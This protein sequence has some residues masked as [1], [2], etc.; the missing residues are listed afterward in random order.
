MLR[1]SLWLLVL[2][3][4]GQTLVHFFRGDIENGIANIFITPFLAWGAWVLTKRHK[5]KK[6]R[7]QNPDIQHPKVTIRAELRDAKS[8]LIGIFHQ[9]QSDL[10]G[11]WADIKKVLIVDYSNR[12]KYPKGAVQSSVRADKK[13][14]PVS[15]AAR[16]IR[17]IATDFEDPKKLVVSRFEPLVVNR[18]TKSQSYSGGGVLIVK[19]DGVLIGYS[20]ARSRDPKLKQ[21]DKKWSQILTIRPNQFEIYLEDHSY[22]EFEPTNL[23]DFLVLTVF[24]QVFQTAPKGF[25]H[26]VGN[27]IG[28]ALGDK[29]RLVADYLDENRES[30]LASKGAIDI[31][32]FDFSSIK[33]KTEAAA[34]FKKPGIGSIL[35]GYR[36]EAQ[37]GRGGFGTV[38][39]GRDTKN[40]ENAVAFKLMNLPEGR[41]IKVGSP[42]FFYYSDRFMDEAKKSLNFTSSAYVLNA[43]EM[44]L[45]PW[46]WIAYPLVKGKSVATLLD[47][48]AVS[49]AGW[50]NLAH[51]LLSG[52]RS[53]DIE[54]LVHLDIKPDNIMM[55]GDRFI[56]LDLGV[57]T[58]QGFEF[59][60]MPS[61]TIDFMAPEVLEANATRDSKI[62]ITGSADV[63]SAG[64]TLLWCLDS[65]SHF[66]NLR[67][68][69]PMERI[70][71]AR[72]HIRTRGITL[73]DVSED[74]R[75]LLEAMLQIDPK[76]R[77]SANELLFAVAPHVD[78]AQKIRQ[79]EEANGKVDEMAR[80]KLESGE[81][82]NLKEKID[83]PFKSWRSLEQ[84]IEAIIEDVRPAYFTIEFYFNDNRESIYIQALYAAG[85]WVMECMSEKFAENDLELRQKA[86][87]V[88]LGWSPPSDSS[89]NYERIEEMISPR[90]MTALFVDALEQAYGISIGNIESMRLNVKNKN[91]Y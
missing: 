52:L 55:N 79:I 42:E 49:D 18:A 35:E 84:Q 30:V 70:L 56:I 85:G 26:A 91:A 33:P 2:A 4:A 36:L 58:I 5:N 6:L 88:D 47:Y 32:K 87:L 46:P 77:P 10:A 90:E 31:G 83:G 73:P 76:K 7:A 12:P 37:L 69:D 71:E 75:N 60:Q 41:N 72:D 54:G 15:N 14:E 20:N 34:V 17:Q 50:W 78:L 13:F 44:G 82:A 53:I 57:A 59:G 80:E 39:L 51:D 89:P 28:S 65:T 21:A 29:L 86:K 66:E 16:R 38:F 64:L 68:R 45:S 11:L 27:P 22:F 25:S 19:R 43:I 63:F 48:G 62:P 3:M 8:N 24:W 9:I 61:G 81:R 74:K 1:I 23:E 67:S 40:P